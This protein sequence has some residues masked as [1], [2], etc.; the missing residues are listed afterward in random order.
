VAVIIGAGA[1]Y[2]SLPDYPAPSRADTERCRADKISH[3]NRLPIADELFDL[4]F[5]DELNEFREAAAIAPYLRGLPVGVSFEQSWRTCQRKGALTGLE[6]W[7][8]IGT[9]FSTL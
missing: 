1:S 5:A 7:W 4:R 9:N 8:A 6:K 3:P 2:D